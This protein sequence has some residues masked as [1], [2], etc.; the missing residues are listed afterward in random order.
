M[1]RRQYYNKWER[2]SDRYAAKSYTEL[3]RVFSSWSKGIDFD[4]MT[5]NTYKAYLK[6]YLNLNTE[7]MNEAYMNVY[8]SVGLTHGRRVGSSINL[9]LKAF[10][11]DAFSS[12]FIQEIKEF[13]AKYGVERIALVQ[14][15]YFNDIVK[16]LETRLERGFT[17][18]EASKEVHKIVNSPKFYRWQAQRI[19]RTESTAAANFGATQSGEV[20]GFV[21]QKEWISARSPRTRRTPPNEYDHLHMNGKRVGLN[22]DFTLRSSRGSVDK[23]SYPGDPKGAAGDVINC[24]CTVAVVPKRDSDGNLVRTS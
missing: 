14:Q 18:V 20:S 9:Q 6:V 7:Q 8:T 23:L 17:M 19:A 16:L 22:E 4:S 12:L 15:T 13:F 10:T 21:M 3:K 1:G 11:F 5:E 2:Y 24:R